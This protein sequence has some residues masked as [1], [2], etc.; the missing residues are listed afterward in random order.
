[1][2]YFRAWNFAP[3]YGTVTSRQRP[4]NGGNAA[5]YPTQPGKPTKLSHALPHQAERRQRPGVLDERTGPESAPTVL[6]PGQEAIAVAF[7]R[8]TRLAL[9]DCLCALQ[10]TIPHLPR[11]ALHQCFQ[12]HG[13][14]RLPLS[15]SRAKAAEK[16]IQRFPSW[17]PARRFRGSADRGRQATPFC[18][19][20]PHQQSG[21]CRMASPHQARGGGR[22]PAPGAW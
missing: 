10:A 2:V 14:S 16:E 21:L 17:P 4:H 18:D 6:S 11:S 15:E 9:D 8:H 3:N 5:R 1:M 20:R 7:R 19:H 22:I 13:I 12:R